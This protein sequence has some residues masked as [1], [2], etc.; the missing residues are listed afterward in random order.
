M[1]ATGQKRNAVLFYGNNYAQDVAYRS[2]FADAQDAFGM[3]TVFMLA[4][5][6]MEGHETGYLSA[7]TLK[8][9][10]PDYKERTWYVSGPPVMV[11]AAKNILL[12][13]GVSRKKIV[14]DFFPGLA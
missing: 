2:L 1:L 3:Q 4:K 6:T 11:T 5:E 12:S 14:T 8:K 9:Y 13:V 7:D 10:T